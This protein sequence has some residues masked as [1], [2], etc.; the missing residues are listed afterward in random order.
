VLDAGAD[1]SPTVKLRPYLRERLDAAILRSVENARAF[2]SKGKT[3][4]RALEKTMNEI[5]R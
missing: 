1:D 4:A 5:W 3:V 2:R